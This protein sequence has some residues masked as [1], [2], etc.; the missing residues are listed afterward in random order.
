MH[1]LRLYIEYKHEK[2]MHVQESVYDSL[3]N[4]RESTKIVP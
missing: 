2:T 3:K 1:T 4:S